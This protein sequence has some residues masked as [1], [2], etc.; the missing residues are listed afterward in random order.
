MTDFDEVIDRRDT[1]SQKWDDLEK[2]YGV[3]ADSGIPLWVADMD[4]RAPPPVN[5]ALQRMVDHGV[6]G[7]YGDDTSF[8][9]AMAGWMKRRHDWTIEPE[10]ALQTHGLVNA[11]AMVI[12]ACSAPGEGVIIFSPVYHAFA[13]IISANDRRMV[14]SPLR[15]EDNRFHMDIAAL[16]A[17]LTGDER[18]LLL[19]SPHN[20]G[21]RVWSAEELR[22]VAAFCE[23]N[24]IILVSDEV[25]H[26]LVMPGHSH[27]VTACVAP[28]VG[29]RLV[30][31]VATSKT[32]NIAGI[33]TGSM[34]I[35]NP[36]L[37]RRVAKARSAMSISNNR[38]GM[39]MAE[40]A[41]Q[42]GDEWLDSLLTYLDGNRR[43]LNQGIEGVPGLSVM[44]LE[45]TYLAWVDFSGTGM[46]REAFT[47]RLKDAGLAPSDGQSFGPEGEL[48]MRFNIACRRALLDEAMGRLADAFSDP[49]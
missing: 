19:C 35:S 44:N 40:A 1:H 45:A 23:R 10:W 28:E 18:I 16:E 2:N 43:A 11:I 12:Q 13:R 21:G 32:F 26:D 36:A 3:P 47:T 9:A 7:Y 17:S 33:E 41:Y 46:A 30:T 15:I 38:F 29:D 34:L 6:H 39:I 37:R 27:H 5:A 25:H 4:F 20:P 42:D 48:C 8:R 24:D 22:D 31:L 49:Q 14:A